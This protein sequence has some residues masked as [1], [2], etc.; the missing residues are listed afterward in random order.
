MPFVSTVRREAGRQLVSEIG[1][2]IAFDTVPTKLTRSRGQHLRNGVGALLDVSSSV[3]FRPSPLAVLLHLRRKDVRANL[4]YGISQVLAAGAP[5]TERE[6]RALIAAVGVAAGVALANR[7]R[8]QRRAVAPSS[9]R[10]APATSPE[11]AAAG[12]AD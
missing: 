8:Q 1:R 3:I 9:A 5:R 4:G 11:P 7:A 2:G 6:R 10:V 12:V